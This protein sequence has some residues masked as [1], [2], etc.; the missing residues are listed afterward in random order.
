[1]TCSTRSAVSCGASLCIV[2]AL[3]GGCSARSDGG[4]G[5]GNDNKF[6]EAIGGKDGGTVD[7]NDDDDDDDGDGNG[8]PEA[9]NKMDILFVIDNSG[10][11]QEE[12][13]N[14]ASNFPK[15]IQVLND[16]RAENGEPL[17]YRLGITTTAVSASLEQPPI[18]PGFPPVAVPVTGD[19][20]RLLKVASCGMTNKWISS[21]DA[22]VA[23][24]FACAAKVGVDGSGFEMH[25]KAVDLALT[26]RV[27]DGSN[28][29]FLREDALLAVVILSD[30]DDCSHVANTITLDPSSTA[31]CPS[32]QLLDGAALVNTLDQVKGDRA[33]WAAAVIAGPPGQATCES[34]FGSADPGNRLESF[35]TAVGTNAIMSSICDGDLSEGLLDAVN[36]F[37]EACQAFVPVL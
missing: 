21:G 27:N 25:F 30:E 7:N 31:A 24:T 23:G 35:I 17:D 9:C 1:M 37:D 13:T 29:G 14:L 12:Q 33:R 18:I 3:L 16:Y 36:T 2:L 22:D 15:F 11:M 28:A 20:G 8:E 19:D 26:D 10:S 6:P 5:V 32:G 4:E 34:D